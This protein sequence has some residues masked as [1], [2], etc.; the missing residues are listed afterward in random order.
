M[1][2]NKR[3]SLDSAALTE[4]WEAVFQSMA[5]DDLE[6]YV[7]SGWMTPESAAQKVGIT[8]ESMRMRLKRMVEL[9]TMEAKKIRAMRSKKACDIFI[10]RPLT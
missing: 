4:A 6:A 9:G 2:K 8:V 5:I 1:R 10:Y 7:D 3:K